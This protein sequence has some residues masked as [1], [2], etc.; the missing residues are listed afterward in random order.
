MSPSFAY[1]ILALIFVIWLTGCARSR[2]S[3]RRM[4]ATFVIASLRRAESCK[5]TDTSNC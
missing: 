5:R 3:A 2:R 4:S 1:I